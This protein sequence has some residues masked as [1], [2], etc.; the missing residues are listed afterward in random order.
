MP[1]RAAAAEIGFTQWRRSVTG[2]HFRIV[3]G[4]P[5]VLNPESGRLTSA[6]QRTV[7]A[8]VG[9]RSDAYVRAQPRRSSSRRS[10][11]AA[12]AREM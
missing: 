3:R 6:D 5:P 8:V 11:T 7:F 12:F 9:R 2:A 10:I 4:A 1:A